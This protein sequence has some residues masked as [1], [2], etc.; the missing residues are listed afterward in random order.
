M[1]QLIAALF[2]TLILTGCA[3]TQS[4][5][6]GIAAYKTAPTAVSI[7]KQ[8]IGED[9]QTNTALA[10]QLYA[11][12][13]LYDK[14]KDIDSTQSFIEFYDEHGWQVLQARAHWGAVI[15]I[16]GQYS[17]RTQRPIPQELVTFRADVESAYGE[18]ATIL[19]EQKES[20]TVSKYI[21]VLALMIK[22]GAASQG[23]II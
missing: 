12:Q 15:T 9:E 21:D 16:V 19:A 2:A 20:E 4:I 8:Y 18:L 22:L 5:V 7:L 3:S 10:P 13:N 17:V 6:S 14:A 11:L 1:K 23:V